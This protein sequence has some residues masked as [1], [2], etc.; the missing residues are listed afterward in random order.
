MDKSNVLVDEISSRVT[1]AV[2]EQ[3]QKLQAATDQEKPIT[4]K[5]CAE[6]LSLSI[7]NIHLKVS[8]GVLPSHN[9]KGRKSKVYFFKSELI[10][11][12]KDKS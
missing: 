1:D 11:F 3:I 8:K 9:I 2:T 12:L 10:S 6:F 4:V 5:E 7:S